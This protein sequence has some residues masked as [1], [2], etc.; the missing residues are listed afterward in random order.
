M[1]AHV[2]AAS[3]GLGVNE[4]NCHP[5]VYGRFMFMHNGGIADFRQIKKSVV[6][7]MREDVYQSLEGATDSEHAFGL[8]LSLLPDPNQTEVYPSSVLCEA[9]RQTLRKITELRVE[10]GLDPEV[11]GSLNF[12]GNIYIAVHDGA[13]CALC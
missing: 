1:F 4:A 10:A 3:P 7:A 6:M 11:G 5:F 13:R 8:F 9:M 12:A 2:R